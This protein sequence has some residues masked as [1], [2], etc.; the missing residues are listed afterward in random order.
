MT[1]N[2]TAPDFEAREGDQFYVQLWVKRSALWVTSS[3][4]YP[5]IKLVQGAGSVA[6]NALLGDI[7]L[8]PVRIPT[9]DW[10]LL[11]VTVTIPVGVRSLRVVFDGPEPSTMTGTL[12]VD[13]IVVRRVTRAEEI[14]D[15]PGEKITTGTVPEDRVENL[16]ATRSAATA[17]DTRSQT[18]VDGV[19]RGTQGGSSSGNAASTVE[20]NLKLSWAKLFDGLGE[21][22]GST[23]RLPSDVQNVSNVLRIDTTDALD[24]ADTAN[25]NA[26][27]A[28]SKAATADGK[29]VDAQSRLDA[30]LSAGSGNLC[31]NPSFADT[32]QYLRHGSVYST[33]VARSGSTSAKITSV[34]GAARY[35]H[36]TTTK[37]GYFDVVSGPSRSY[38]VECWVRGDTSNTI[39]GTGNVLGIGVWAYAGDGSY[40]DSNGVIYGSADEIGKGTWVKLSGT[41]TF[42]GNTSIAKA[43]AQIYMPNYVAAGNSWYVDDVIVRDITEAQ[44]ADTK[45]VAAQTAADTADAKAQAAQDQLRA[46]I[47][48][49][50]N[51]VYDSSFETSV[52]GGRRQSGQSRSGGWSMRTGAGAGGISLSLHLT[53]TGSLVEWPTDNSRVY[54]CEAWVYPEQSNSHATGNISLRARIRRSNDSRFLYPTSVLMETDTLTRGV[55]QRISGYMDM[56]GMGDVVSWYL[57]LRRDSSCG[58]DVFWWDDVRVVDVTDAYNAAQSVRATNAQLYGAANADAPQST[59]IANAVPGLQASKIVEGEFNSAQIPTLAQ[60]K[61]VGLPP[62]PVETTLEQHGAEITILKAERD[63]AATQGKNISVTFSGLKNASELPKTTGNQRWS[64]RYSGSGSGTWGIVNGRASWTGSTSG[65]RSATVVYLGDG[66][67]GS[68][69]TLTDYQVLRGVLVNPPIGQEFTAMARVSGNSFETDLDPNYYVWAKAVATIG[70]FISVSVT[71]SI[72]CVVNGASHTWVDGIPLTWSMEMT[73]KCGVDGDLRRYQVFSGT[74]LVLDYRE[75]D[76][77]L[78]AGDGTIRATPG[79][80]LSSIGSTFRRWGAIARY[81]GLSNSGT[82]SSVSVS[83]DPPVVYAGSVARMAR[84]S[85]GTATLASGT[86]ALPSNFF[87]DDVFESR[88]ITSNPSTGTFTVSK[89]GMYLITGR[90]RLSSF[91]ASITRIDLQVNN[92]TTQH[93]ETI[94]PFDSFHNAQGTEYALTGT[95]LQYLYAGQSVRLVTYRQ[96]GSSSVLRGG[97]GGVE[98][99]FS[100]SGLGTLT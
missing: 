2:P 96:T 72:G 11:G 68:E 74:E 28:D 35:V 64:I 39:T 5:R 23:S 75:D 93:G 6:P 60:S 81:S 80:P 86:R 99:Y 44:A 13:E 58:D 38:Y 34:D 10:T 49:G 65:S 52:W 21:T 4:V 55:W 61:V 18:T 50:I 1:Y 73:L 9:T 41:V 76:R 63:A 51:L 95:W 87:D 69:T 83:D 85:T 57:Y 67:A 7:K 71:G 79:T 46:A 16:P 53:N 94:W 29:A 78:E 90:I 48:S 100:I 70:G 91:F 45:A 25:T 62:T 66:T 43:R 19:W 26:G 98:T 32:G 59:I 24:N 54:Y 8:L 27:L 31:T 37:T 92:S 42:S 36:L 40:A 82:V 56:A 14:G 88:D 77:K 20:S 97:A 17:A 30:S 15:L 84:L 22:T 3:T 33:T 12:W 47:S 89:S